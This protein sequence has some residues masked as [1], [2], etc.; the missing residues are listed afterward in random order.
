MSFNLNPHEQCALL[1]YLRGDR[2][3][4]GDLIDVPLKLEASLAMLTDPIHV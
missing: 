1:L 3:L 4:P 2:S